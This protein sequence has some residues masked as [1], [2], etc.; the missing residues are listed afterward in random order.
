M[1]DYEA[2]LAIVI[3]KQGK[4]IP[5]EQAGEYIFGYTCANDV[6]ARD[7]QKFLDTQWTR[8]KGF[9]SF[10]PLGPWLITDIDPGNLRVC[11]RLNGKVMQDQSTSQMLFSVP[12]I[13]S[14]VSS[15]MTLLPGT[16]ILTGTPEGVGMARTPPVYMKEGDVI[17]IEI[18]SVGCLRNTISRESP[19]R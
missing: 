16:V 1:V 8:A 2:E 19:G 6:T 7:C 15:F 11:S 4:H 10:C 9:D 12:A 17:E 14:F 3:G 18:E 13:V 5:I